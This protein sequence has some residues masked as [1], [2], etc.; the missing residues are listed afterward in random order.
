MVRKILAA[1]LCLFLFVPL[2]AC[3][4]NNTTGNT[5]KIYYRNLEPDYTSLHSSGVIS[6]EEI[7]VS[8]TLTNVELILNQY[9]CKPKD[10]LHVSPYPDGTTLTEVYIQ[11]N[12]AYVTM[13]A[14]FSTLSGKDMTV[15]CVCLTLTVI[16]ATQTQSVTITAPGL[17][18]SGNDSITLDKSCI[19]L[20]D[21]VT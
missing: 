1:T 4:H 9:L 8:D 10:K 13:S 7:K 2:Q 3:H 11:D 16:S 18:I 12:M 21:D 14:E 20:F 19:Q 6:A 17:N 15:A 5:V